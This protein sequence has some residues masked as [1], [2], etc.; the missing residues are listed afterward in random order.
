[1]VPPRRI[2]SVESDTNVTVTTTTETEA[3]QLD[4]VTRTGPGRR[5]RLIGRCVMTTGAA[6]TTVTPRIRRGTGITGDLIGEGTAVTIGAA[7]GGNEV[8]TVEAVDTLDEPAGVSY[9][10]TVQQ[11]AATGNGTILTASLEAQII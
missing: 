2:I 8:F 9:V 6:T 5:I 4:G 10:V 1:M 11:A 3:V 7:A